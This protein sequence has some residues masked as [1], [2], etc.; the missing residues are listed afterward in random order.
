MKQLV[1]ATRNAHKVRELSEMIAPLGWEAVSLERI[2]PNAPEVEETGS[3]FAEN[4]AI[5]AIS[6]YQAT[7]GMPSIADDS[8]ICVDAL[9]G[10]PGIFS[11]RYAGSTATDT[12]NNNALL[13]ALRGQ[14]DRN[15]HF[16]C[17]LALVCHR[18][19]L[20]DTANLI[21]E[22]PDLPDGAVLIAVEGRVNGVIAHTAS[23]QKGFGYDP[24]FYVPEL[25]CTF[26]QVPSEDKH[27]LSHRGQAFRSLL[28]ILEE[29]ASLKKI[30]RG[31]DLSSGS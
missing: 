15:A 17:A 23:G 31:P 5:K 8:G 10:A 7:G 27:A 11:A 14:D 4:A 18:T 29:R 25:G 9:Q 13:A 19:E 2:V 22:W 1:F 16:F 30:T 26:A 20:V 3:T 12:D 6:A 21:T 24:L 28:S